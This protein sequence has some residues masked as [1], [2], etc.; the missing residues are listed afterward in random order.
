MIQDIKFIIYNFFH[1]KK[2]IKQKYVKFSHFGFDAM[3]F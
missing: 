1:E 3:S 2:T